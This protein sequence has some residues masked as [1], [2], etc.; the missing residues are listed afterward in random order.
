VTPFFLLWVM[1]LALKK[2]ASYLGAM[3]KE[4]LVTHRLV[5]QNEKA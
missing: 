2:F 5:N 3:G 1:L 4:A